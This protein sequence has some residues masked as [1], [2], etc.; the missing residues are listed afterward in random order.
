MID[1]IVEIDKSIV[2]AINSAHN[3]FWDEVMWFISSKIFWL[4][5]LSLIFFLA[6]KN[7]EVKSF[8]IFVICGIGLYA[9]TDQVCLHFFKN[10]FLR[11]RPSY[12][13]ELSKLLHFYHND[14]EY[15]RGKELASFVSS[16]AANYFAI[17]S[18]LFFAL[19]KKMSSLFWV[20]LVIGILICYSR[21]YLGVHYP[22]DLIGGAT[23]GILLAY[24]F[25]KY[26]FRKLKEINS[27]E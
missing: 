17:F 9:I 15:Y 16:H 5:P 7:L 13:P 6:W 12:H 10:L 8:W 24:L 14:G 1:F 3:P 22:S 21:L 4:L 27:K 26:V 19:G 18:F 23:V 2:V 25:E 11:Q 20:L